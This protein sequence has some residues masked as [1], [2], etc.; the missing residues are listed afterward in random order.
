[1]VSFSRS[2]STSQSVPPAVSPQIPLSPPPSLSP[3]MLLHRSLALNYLRV[4][5]PRLVTGSSRKKTGPG[6][7]LPRDLLKASSTLRTNLSERTL[8]VYHSS[9]QRGF[10]CLLPKLTS[11]Q[12]K[13]A[14]G[15]KE[16]DE[17]D[18]SPLA[19]TRDK[20]Q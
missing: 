1:M 9:Q 18:A 12:Q 8:T 20:C 7:T 19:Q 3:H 14:N 10:R 11:S 15:L 6:L 5:G 4:S 16:S 13:L 17:Q 2:G